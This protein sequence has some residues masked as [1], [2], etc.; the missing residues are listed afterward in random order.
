M[1]SFNRLKD[2]TKIKEEQIEWQGPFAWTG[3]EELN[4]L[5]KIPD[6]EGIYLWTFRYKDGYVVYSIGITNS[7][8]KRFRKHTLEYNKGNYTVLDVKVAE[9]GEREEVWHGWKYAKNHQEE[10]NTRKKDILKAVDYQLES[11]RIFI[12]SVAD[13]RLRERIEAA[14]MHNIYYTKEPWAELADRG[15]FLTARFNSEIPVNINNVC[16]NKIY[17]LPKRIEV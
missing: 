9:N 17:G 6:I 14:L 12:A 3:Y 11:F 16:S 4:G 7:T 2:E 15:M 1:W 13:K 5:D 8:K 10:F